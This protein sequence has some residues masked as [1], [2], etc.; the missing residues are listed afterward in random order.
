[1][2]LSLPYIPKPFKSI[3]IAIT[4]TLV[5][6]SNIVSNAQNSVSSNL[7]EVASNSGNFSTLITALTK[8]DLLSTF[9]TNTKFTVLAPTNEAFAKIPTST[10]N[11][12]LAPENKNILIKIL[13]YHVI[14]GESKAAQIIN[15][16]ELST[17]DGGKIRVNVA[18]S[19]VSLNGDSTVTFTD[20]LTS[21][22]IL[23]TIDTVL[24]PSD[25]NL[26]ELAVPLP[27]SR[28]IVDNTIRSGGTQVIP[29]LSLVVN[30]ILIMVASN[31]LLF[32]KN[33]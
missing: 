31:I 11:F 6:F 27:N 13:K 4:L 24:V 22:G 23:H 7:V 32:R 10:L 28:A 5:I 18:D 25:V 2:I 29:L 9:T 14:A 16:R 30:F 17:L 15:L 33:N 21:N 1:M 26:A 8:A 20:T 12:L 3:F 19:K